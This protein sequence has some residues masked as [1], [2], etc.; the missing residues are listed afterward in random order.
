MPE[1]DEKENN[2]KNELSTRINLENDIFYC[3]ICKQANQKSQETSYCVHCGHEFLVDRN[4]QLIPKKSSKKKKKGWK[5]LTGLTISLEL[6]LLWQYQPS[7]LCFF[8]CL[9]KSILIQFFLI[10]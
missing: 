1:S 5:L 4:I 8:L 10:F 3:P 9:Q 7:S 6:I 2:E